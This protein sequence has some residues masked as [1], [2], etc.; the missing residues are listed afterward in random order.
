MP[1]LVYLEVKMPTDR[2]LDPSI[3]SKVYVVMEATLNLE[4]SEDM[5]NWKTTLV[6]IK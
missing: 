4:K 5:T 3:C 6:S 1:L 2:R